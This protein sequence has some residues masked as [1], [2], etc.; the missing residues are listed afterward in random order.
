M[1]PYYPTSYPPGYAPAPYQGQYPV[2]YAAQPY[3]YYPPPPPP[4]SP[5]TG[6]YFYQY[7]HPYQRWYAGGANGRRRRPHC[8]IRAHK[9]YRNDAGPAPAAAPAAPP[10][11]PRTAG[12]E[13]SVERM[14]INN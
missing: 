2:I 14:N 10:A 6:P 4:P 9:R 3:G 12:T 8:T 11:A 5:A 13:L 7:G 1:N